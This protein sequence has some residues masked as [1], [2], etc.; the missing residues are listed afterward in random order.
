MVPVLS[1]D[2]ISAQLCL[3]LASRKFCQVTDSAWATKQKETIERREKE[4]T[5]RKSFERKNGVKH[6]D[7]I[8]IGVI[9][10]YNVEPAGRCEP[11]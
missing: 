8:K 10:D 9:R 5:I 6:T 1:I 3:E 4:S 2:T 11:L 7:Q